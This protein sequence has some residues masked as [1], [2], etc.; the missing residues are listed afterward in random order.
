[1]LKGLT[2]RRIRDIIGGQVIKQELHLS[3]DLLELIPHQFL[4]DRFDLAGL[5]IALGSRLK[6]TYAIKRRTLLPVD[7]LDARE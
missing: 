3:R 6:V 2:L 7:R 4:P 5:H 1:M